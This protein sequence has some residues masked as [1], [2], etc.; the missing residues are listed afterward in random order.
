MWFLS[1]SFEALN[2]Y[3]FESVRPENFI[4]IFSW[5]KITV[6]LNMLKKSLM[7]WSVSVI[8]LPMSLMKR[9]HFFFIEG[10]Q[11]E[12]V[13]RRVVVHLEIESHLLSHVLVRLQRYSVSRG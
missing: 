6:K 2:C 4:V 12:F 7:N 13:R 1:R 8:P 5:L 11:F 3:D 9:S 10:L